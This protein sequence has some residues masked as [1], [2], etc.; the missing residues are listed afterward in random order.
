MPLEDLI[1]AGGRRKL[2]ALRF[3]LRAHVVGRGLSWVVLALVG[4]VFLT[5][6][7]DR[8]LNMDRAQRGLIVGLS[9]VGIGYVL[10]RFLLRPLRVPMDA[11]ELALV[12]ER[13]YPQL[14]DRLISAL[15]FA[16]RD[17]SR[18]GA[19]EDLIRAVARQANELTEQLD[20]AEPVEG[21]RALKRLGLAAGGVTVLMI[22][23]IFNFQ[24]MGLWFRRNVLFADVPWPRQ[25][26]LT[27]EGA[28]ELRVVRG[29]RLMVTVQADADHVVPREVRYP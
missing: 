4:G 17:A 28:P 8:G 3:I 12:L 15:Q 5:L 7:I 23:T 10:G 1:T 19:S 21:A 26:Y 13:H 29:E 14:D 22:F 6:A 20:A 2:S 9:L 27:V 24:L 18:T 25:T 11:E 16:A